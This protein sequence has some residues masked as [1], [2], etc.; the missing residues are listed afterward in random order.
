M[1][2]S[3]DAFTSESTR[4]Y[5]TTEV[6]DTP[7]KIH[8]EYIGKGEVSS[9][10][11]FNYN[12]NLSLQKII[13]MIIKI[14][15]DEFSRLIFFISKYQPED[16]TYSDLKIKELLLLIRYKIDSFNYFFKTDEIRNPLFLTI[17]LCTHY[18]EGILACLLE[19]IGTLIFLILVGI[20]MGVLMI[21]ATIVDPDQCHPSSCGPWTGKDKR[22]VRGQI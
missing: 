9:I 11:F 20:L 18:G 12:R 13:N 3:G 19:G 22:W 7:T 15:D 10:T 1:L 4:L 16:G 2:N 6:K 14:D 5:P 17:Y 21:F 8:I